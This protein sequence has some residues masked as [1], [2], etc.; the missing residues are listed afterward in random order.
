MTSQMGFSGEDGTCQSH[1]HPGALSQSSW[2]VVP[3]TFTF[4]SKEACKKQFK[5][6]FQ[7]LGVA[8]DTSALWAAHEILGKT[9]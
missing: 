4:I 9:R 7:K 5:M 2:A 3:V 8:K 6:H 1:G